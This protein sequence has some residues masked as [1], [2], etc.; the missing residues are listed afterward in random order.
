MPL[1]P[2]HMNPFNT[3]VR[4]SGTGSSGME[5]TMM[6]KEVQMPPSEFFIVMGKICLTAFKA[7]EQ[8]SS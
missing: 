3:M 5:K 1:G 4:A 6:L 2:R 7:M 8:A